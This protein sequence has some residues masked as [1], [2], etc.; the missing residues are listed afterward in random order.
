LWFWTHLSV[1]GRLA[2]QERAMRK[3]LP[4]TVKDSHREP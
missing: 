4:A 1:E 2:G 3:W